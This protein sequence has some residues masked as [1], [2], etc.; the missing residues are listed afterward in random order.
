M[1]GNIEND[2]K[3]VFQVVRCIACEKQFTEVYSFCRV[4]L[5][6]YPGEDFTID[7]NDLT[8]VKSKAILFPEILSRVC[9]SG[10]KATEKRLIKIFRKG[11]RDVW[12][13]D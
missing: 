13:D 6:D 2:G 9:S 11:M 10:N 5:T 4:I 3:E 7:F 8:S 12:H 1:Y